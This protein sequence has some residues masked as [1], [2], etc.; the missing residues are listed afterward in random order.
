VLGRV[1]EDTSFWRAIVRQILRTRRV[2]H[3]TV[4]DDHN[5]LIFHLHRPLYLLNRCGPG[6][7]PRGYMARI[8]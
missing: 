7:A 6:L 3:A 1:I 5:R 2:V 4:A 8:A